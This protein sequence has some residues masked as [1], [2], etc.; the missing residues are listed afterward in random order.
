MSD[1]PY[2]VVCDQEGIRYVL[3]TVQFMGNYRFASVGVKYIIPRTI[4]ARSELLQ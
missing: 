1:Q 3:A 4:V 2:L